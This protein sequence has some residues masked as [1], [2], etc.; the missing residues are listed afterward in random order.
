MSHTPTCDLDPRGHPDPVLLAAPGRAGRGEQEAA[1]RRAATAA[2]RVSALGLALTGGVELALALLTGSVSLLGDAIHNLSDVSTSLVVFL[3]FWVSKRAPTSRYPYGY[4]RAE[5]LAGLGVALV[6]WASAVFAGYESWAKLVSGRGTSHLGWGVAAALL[7]VAGNQAVA[8]Y[9]LRVGRRIHSATLVADARHSWL[10]AISSVGALVGLVLVG[11]GQRWGD[12]VAGFAVT[13]FIVNVGVEVTRELAGHLMD[14]VEPA[15]LEAARRAAETVPGVA[16]PLV[17]GRW[18][19]R[20]LVL[21][22][23]AQLAPRCSLAEADQLGAAVREAV[24]AAV[25]EARIVEWRPRGHGHEP[26]PA[27]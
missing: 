22:V 13:L 3:G 1:D 17:R 5:D 21:E 8:R 12:P 18:L 27:R 11:V 2:V 9:K 4:G 25:E 15:L 24:L 14:G 23:E 6:I 16:A 20:S 10:D 7:G 26:R 19:G